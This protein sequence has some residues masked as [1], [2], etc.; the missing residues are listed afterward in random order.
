MI[1]SLRTIVLLAL[2]DIKNFGTKTII[3]LYQNF[4]YVNNDKFELD[5]FLAF[6]TQHIKTNQEIVEQLKDNINS[7]KYHLSK[8]EMQN[9]EVISYFDSSYP[10]QLKLLKNPPLFLFCKGNTNLLSNIKN[11]AV[12]GTRENS[13]IGEKVAIKTAEFFSTKNYT[14][15]SGLARGIDTA[16]HVGAL[17]VNG[18]TIAV[19]TDIMKIYPAENKELA[20]NILR[21]DGLLFSEIAPWKNIYR[22]AF[23]DRDRLQSGLSLGTFVI[24]TD[25]KGGTMHTVKFTLEQ[26]RHLFVPDYTLLNYTNGFSKI[27]GT[28]YLL[29]EGKAKAYSRNNYDDILF[30]LESKQNVLI[31]EYTI[32]KNNK[33]K[34]L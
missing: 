1:P 21:N 24:E 3:T 28:K 16:A 15:V 14:I 33:R 9:V 4:S 17:N 34:L 12:V 10:F 29:K 13:E 18:N 31:N 5:S 8:D 19:L 2:N 30:L 23:V 11:I 26:D 6:L 20:E 32:Q 25:I 7:I 27:N 22:S